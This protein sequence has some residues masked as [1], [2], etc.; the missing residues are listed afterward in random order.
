MN[1]FISLVLLLL[2]SLNTSSN[3]QGDTKGWQ[4]LA[5]ESFDKYCYKTRGNFSHLSEIVAVEQLNR[6]T[7]EFR[8]ETKARDSITTDSYILFADEDNDGIFLMFAMPDSCTV[9]ASGINTGDVISELVASYGL[10]KVGSQNNGYNQA[11]I[12]V[13]SIVD[14]VEDLNADIG[15]VIIVSPIISNDDGV[16]TM[17]FMPPETALADPA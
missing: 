6:V 7:E 13:P 10:K 4:D 5:Q 1:K 9:M 12:Y 16:I 2:I 11:S 14:E 3:E 17:S 8:R 15:L